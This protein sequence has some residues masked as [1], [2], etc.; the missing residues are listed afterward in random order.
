MAA[1]VSA[2]TAY[3]A[4]SLSSKEQLA[5]WNIDGGCKACFVRPGGPFATLKGRESSPTANSS[6]LCWCSLRTRCTGFCGGEVQ[7]GVAAIMRR[8]SAARSVLRRLSWKIETPAA[9][10]IGGRSPPLIRCPRL[11]RQSPPLPLPGLRCL[12]ARADV[13]DCVLAGRLGCCG[14][15]SPQ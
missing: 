9:S 10:R 14:P 3:S 1:A 5:N 4:G 11:L 13:R 7:I 6:G 12:H 2:M 15:P 8:W